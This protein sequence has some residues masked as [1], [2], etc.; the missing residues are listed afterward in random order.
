MAYSGLAIADYFIEKA[1]EDKN[2]ITNMLVLKMIYFTQG[3]AFS[4]LGIR[5]I[6][7]DFYAWKLGPVEVKTYKEFKKYESNKITDI[8]HKKNEELEKLKKKS[9]IVK[10]LDKIYTKLIGVNPLILSARTHEIDSPWYNT[11]LYEKID[12]DIIEE[13][14]KEI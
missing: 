2:P 1:I 5:L 4:E 11:S 14:F 3:F 9:D 6:K 8:S 7:D 10:F 13:Y 12:S